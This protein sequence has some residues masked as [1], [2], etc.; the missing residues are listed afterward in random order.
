MVQ[1]YDHTSP[2]YLSTVRKFTNFSLIATFCHTLLKS[3]YLH[4]FSQCFLH[5]H[6]CYINSPTVPE[7]E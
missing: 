7:K 5:I 3:L 4:Q 6:I 2:T 1:S